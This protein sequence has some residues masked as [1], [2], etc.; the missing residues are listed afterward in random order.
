[1]EDT[2]ILLG[3]INASLKKNLGK[4][5]IAL[6]LVF[7]VS[8]LLAPISVVIISVGGATAFFLAALV[9]LLIAVIL[10]ML[11]IS[12]A[13]MCGKMYRDDPCVLGNL[14]DSFR[15]WRRC[16]TLSL[17]Y[18]VSAIVICIVIVQG[19]I[20]VAFLA[21]GGNEGT[22]YSEDVLGSMISFMPVLIMVCM[23]IFFLLVLL[24]TSFTHLVLMDNQEMPLLSVLQENFRLLKG[25][26]FQLV[27]FLFRVG[28][29]WLV[30]AFIFL[31]GS[32]GIVSAMYL[33]PE[34]AEGNLGVLQLAAQICDMVYFICAYTTLIRLVTGVAAFYQ[35]IRD[36]SKG[37]TEGQEQ[38][39]QISLGQD[40]Q[41]S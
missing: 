20:L 36:E 13:Q 19:G 9:M 39:L 41:E 8:G 3:K 11:Q 26:K 37:T 17:G 35:A 6:L 15:D 1:M 33:Q 16:S 24:P 18:A 29:F 12:F 28:G 7:L 32:F 27:K 25:K 38:P 22:F 5:I 4:I 31:I 14:L 40:N 23:G 21:S 10:F 34:T 2:R 30:G